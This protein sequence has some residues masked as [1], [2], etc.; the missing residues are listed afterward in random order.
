M[1]FNLNNNKQ[2]SMQ[3]SYKSGV[4]SDVISYIINND[5]GINKG[6]ENGTNSPRTSLFSSSTTNGGVG[7]NNQIK[8]YSPANIVFDQ[9]NKNNNFSINKSNT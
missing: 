1:D 2:L 5:L 7:F 8:E 9:V 6:V 4:N 3:N